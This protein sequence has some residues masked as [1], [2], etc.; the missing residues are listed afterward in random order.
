MTGNTFSI[1]NEKP[2]THDKYGFE[3]LEY[4]EIGELV[5]LPKVREPISFSVKTEDLP[6]KVNRGDI[7]GFKINDEKVEFIAVKEAGGRT[8]FGEYF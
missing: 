3:L 2:E 8:M 6:Y 4:T 7:V 1:S 5:D